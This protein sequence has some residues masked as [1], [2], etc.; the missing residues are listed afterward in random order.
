MPLN[1]LGYVVDYLDIESELPNTPLND[2]YAGITSWVSGQAS[3]AK[4]RQLSKW[5]ASRA[6]EG[7]PIAILGTFGFPLDLTKLVATE[8]GL[9]VDEKG[10]E[11]EMQKQK[12]E[13]TEN[14]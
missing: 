14:K 6:A 5:L 2:K 3:L 8:K 4:G 12:E 7:M 13:T 11:A 10:F 9:T 1:H